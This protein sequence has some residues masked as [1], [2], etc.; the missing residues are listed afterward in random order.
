VLPC[1][2]TTA[3]AFYAVIGALQ[4]SHSAFSQFVLL[5]GERLSYQKM[6]ARMVGRLA[7]P[8]STLGLLWS[9]QK[10]FSALH[11][12]LL[13][14]RELSSMSGVCFSPFPRNELEIVGFNLRQ[15][16]K[17]RQQEVEKQTDGIISDA[18]TVNGSEPLTLQ[19][20]SF[21]FFNFNL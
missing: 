9:S 17:R 7:R 16:L 2:Y 18:K 1:P 19:V 13:P 11:P 6:L 20:R 21:F 8:V 3:A 5:I 10:P 14:S 12:T 15:Q 4:R